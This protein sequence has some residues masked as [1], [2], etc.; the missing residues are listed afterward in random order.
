MSEAFLHYVWQFQYFDKHELQTTSGDTIQIFHPGTR[1][2]HAGPDFQ[3][4]RMK[5]NE[6][7]WI[8]SAEIH[9]QASGWMDHKHDLDA[10]Y[11]NVVLGS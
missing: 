5:I 7:E 10:A 4:A 3:N 6:M 11:E 9:I 1:N 8:G 2:I